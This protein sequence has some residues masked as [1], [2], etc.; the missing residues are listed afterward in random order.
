MFA[1]RNKRN[2]A[3]DSVDKMYSYFIAAV[4]MLYKLYSS[5]YCH[6]YTVNT[7]ALRV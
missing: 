5:C 1:V 4:I 2:T 7:A 3:T 6:L